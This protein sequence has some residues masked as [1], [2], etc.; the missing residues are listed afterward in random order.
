[1]WPDIDFVKWKKNTGGKGLEVS[2]QVKQHPTGFIGSA[3]AIIF[4]TKPE[5]FDNSQIFSG[6]N[7]WDYLGAG[8]VLGPEGVSDK[9]GGS[10]NGKVLAFGGV[11]V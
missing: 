5:V 2:S 10:T 4:S 11:E 6:G 1:M 8:W 9:T 7:F 3:D